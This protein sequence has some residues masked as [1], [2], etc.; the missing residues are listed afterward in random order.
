[1]PERTSGRNTRRT[2]TNERPIGEWNDYE[3]IVDGG[4]LALIVNG[5]VLNEAWDVE[6]VAG[7]ICLQSEGAPI[8]FRRVRLAEIR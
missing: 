1:D 6:E 2:H 8:H 7:K 5:E 4:R 3:I